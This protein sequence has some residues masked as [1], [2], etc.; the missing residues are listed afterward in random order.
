MVYNYRGYDGST[1]CSFLYICIMILTKEETVYDFK[2][3]TTTVLCV[4]HYDS[5]YRDVYRPSFLKAM[6]E[7]KA[8]GIE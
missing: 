6:R 8:R 1:Y 5:Y 7:L 2:T 3:R 4:T